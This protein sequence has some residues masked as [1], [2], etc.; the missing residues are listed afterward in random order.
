[1]VGT[2]ICPPSTAYRLHKDWD[3]SEL[4]MVPDAG[5]SASE[6]GIIN[7]LMKATRKLSYQLKK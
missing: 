5:H 3:G 4:I 6:P 1:M 7:A 2:L